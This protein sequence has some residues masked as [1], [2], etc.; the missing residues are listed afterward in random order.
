[1]ERN[2]QFG[3]DVPRPISGRALLVRRHFLIPRVSGAVGFAAI[4]SRFA[5][6]RGFSAGVAK[7]LFIE[8]SCLFSVGIFRPASENVI[9]P[10]VG[11]VQAISER[12]NGICP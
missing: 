1:M 9:E 2:D 6:T 12:V 8:G 7:A 3:V 4:P 10:V 11:G 5:K